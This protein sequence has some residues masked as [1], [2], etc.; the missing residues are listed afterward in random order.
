MTSINNEHP[1]FYCFSVNF[2]KNTSF[3]KTLIKDAHSAQLVSRNIITSALK[4][5]EAEL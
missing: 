2:F 4:L 3:L 1:P 5:I